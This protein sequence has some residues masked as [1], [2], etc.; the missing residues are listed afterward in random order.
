MKL[1]VKVS[2]TSEHGD[3]PGYAVIDVT[4]ERIEHFRHLSQVCSS[5][6]LAQVKTH[7]GPE[8]WDQADE[9]RLRGDALH[10]DGNGNVHYSAYPKYGSY[11]VETFLVTIG[12]LEL[13]LTEAQHPYMSV[14]NGIAYYPDSEADD[15]KALY[16]AAA[17]EEA[18]EE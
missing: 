5:N 11:H 10:V 6:N 12:W 9:L 16:E 17:Q 1:I 18:D 14:I 8:M 13:L 7:E 4:P 2:A 15:L 3:P